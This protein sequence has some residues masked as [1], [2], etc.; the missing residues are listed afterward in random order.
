MPTYY[1]YAVTSKSGINISEVEQYLEIDTS[2]ETKSAVVASIPTRVVT[3]SN[4]NSLSYRTTYYELTE[5]EASNL[6]NYPDVLGVEIISGSFEDL[7]DNDSKDRVLATGSISHINNNFIPVTPTNLITTNN[8]GSL[9]N[10]AL[11]LHSFPSSSNILEYI[12]NTVN[13]VSS[14][15]TPGTG[16]DNLFN[17]K[18]SKT[19]KNVDLFFSDGFSLRNHAE[20]FNNDGSPKISS[21]YTDFIIKDLIPRNDDR[22]HFYY[23]RRSYVWPAHTSL[24][25][26]HC[27]S[28]AYGENYGNA[29]NCNPQPQWGTPVNPYI[30]D[31]VRHYHVSKSLNPY[32][33]YK[34]PTIWG[35]SSGYLPQPKLHSDFLMPGGIVSGS[36]D[37]FNAISGVGQGFRVNYENIDYFIISSSV[38][39]NNFNNRY[40][41]DSPVPHK[42]YYINSNNI[43]T[44]A[45]KL[46][47]AFNFLEVNYSSNNLQ[48]TSSE[49]INWYITVY[50]GSQATLES[51][52]GGLILNMSGSGDTKPYFA[53]SEWA[54]LG[55]PIG[56]P[57]K[58]SKYAAPRADYFLPS[59]NADY[60]GIDNGYNIP[61]GA[62]R[63]LIYY[64]FPLPAQLE[65][66]N[67]AVRAAQEEASKK[68]VILASSYGNNPYMAMY[69]SC[70]SEDEFH[71]SKFDMNITLT[72]PLNGNPINGHPYNSYFTVSENIYRSGQSP[73]FT[74]GEKIYYQR[75][76]EHHS[77][78]GTGNIIVNKSSS[79]YLNRIACNTGNALDVSLYGNYTIAATTI[80][81]N[82]GSITGS[83]NFTHGPT[84][85][86]NDNDSFYNLNSLYNS[87]TEF[88]ASYNNLWEQ[89]IYPDGNSTL[90]NLNVNYKPITSSFNAPLSESAFLYY[91]W[92]G[93]AAEINYRPNGTSGT[94]DPRTFGIERAAARF[95]G[96]SASNPLLVGF[97]AGYLEENPNA[98]VN[99]VRNW[100]DQN[101][102]ETIVT[103]SN[104]IINTPFDGFY[105]IAKDND[106]NPDGIYRFISGSTDTRKEGLIQYA[107]FTSPKVFTYPY[108]DLSIQLTKYKNVKLT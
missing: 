82:N 87:L 26:T 91:T 37:L 52:G 40:I 74:A 73:T 106:I 32:T 17:Y 103:G 13:N 67:I 22:Q 25:G 8:S 18:S 11:I 102:I 107:P 98:N 58:Y 41:G 104:N 34:D 56:L 59:P 36:F 55:I 85:F 15:N 21:K 31:M 62:G 5:A 23:I 66:N 105:Y 42:I 88:T 90:Y 24:H 45:S 51:D 89:G 43:S 93:S 78:I 80:F 27:H 79:A 95:G 16:N 10:P 84:N 54:P 9:A 96:T 53:I 65:F 77:V 7:F 69:T 81:E 44:W 97:L 2:T 4:R 60:H 71:R 57:N 33:G 99:D 92:P 38:N 20:F 29:I 39:N 1:E 76:R 47:T 30:Y 70:S 94:D 28:L 68:G 64:D 46:N 19:G 35:K 83:S 63:F 48:L 49:N 14:V 108:T 75:Y 6:K 86:Y 100:L 61:F 3:S 50:T 101:S 72:N 12:Y